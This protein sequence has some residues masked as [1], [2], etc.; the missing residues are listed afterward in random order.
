MIK[1]SIIGYRDKQKAELRGYDSFDL[2]EGC[3]VFKWS[4]PEGDVI[5]V[6]LDLISEITCGITEE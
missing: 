1:Y 6:P 5:I 3:A 4:N 2:A